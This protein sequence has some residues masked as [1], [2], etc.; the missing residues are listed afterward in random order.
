MGCRGQLS[1]VP[2]EASGGHFPVLS[3]ICT[4]VYGC[5]YVPYVCSF[6]CGCGDQKA[7]SPLAPAV[8]VLQPLTQQQ[9]QAVGRMSA[10]P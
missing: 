3:V 7:L 5:E 2:T 9:T 4:Y 6:M 10:E 8:T 1:T